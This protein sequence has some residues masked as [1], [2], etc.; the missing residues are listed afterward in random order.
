MTKLCGS[1]HITDAMSGAHEPGIQK[2]WGYVLMSFH[3]DQIG[4]KDV[5]FVLGH[6]SIGDNDIVAELANESEA[7]QKAL[8]FSQMGVP[9]IR[10]RA[11]EAL[12][13]KLSEASA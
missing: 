6:R 9:A 8:S 4:G 1:T 3:R 2:E 5:W 13:A 7:A 11:Y 10:G 12:L